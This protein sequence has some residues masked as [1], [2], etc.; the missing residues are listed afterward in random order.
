MQATSIAAIQATFA[1]NALSPRATAVDSVTGVAATAPKVMVEQAN[2]AM[3]KLT[4]ILKSKDEK[5]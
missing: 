2:V 3:L 5:A 1:G 4:G